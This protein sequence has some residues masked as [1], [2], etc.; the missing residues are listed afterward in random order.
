MTVFAYSHLYT[1]TLM[2]KQECTYVEEYIDVYMCT[3]SYIYTRGIS[4]WA[5]D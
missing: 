5:Y 1:Q 2:C 4:H 3:H